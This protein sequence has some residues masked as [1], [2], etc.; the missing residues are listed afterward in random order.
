MNQDKLII[1]M[2]P[3]RRREKLMLKSLELLDGLQVK[4]FKGKTGG[5]GLLMRQ[6][7]DWTQALS[8]LT[9]K[10]SILWLPP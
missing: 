9:V 5:K 8:I 4:I 10:S 7:R 3:P 1:V 2:V 6:S